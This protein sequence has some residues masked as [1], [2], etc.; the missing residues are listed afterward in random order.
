MVRLRSPAGGRRGAAEIGGRLVPLGVLAWGVGGC[1]GR[2][3]PG[4]RGGFGSIGPGVG[5]RGEGCEPLGGGRCVCEERQACKGVR[6]VLGGMFRLI[7]PAVREE[8]RPVRYRCVCELQTHRGTKCVWRWLRAHH[9]FRCAR[10]PFGAHHEVA[11]GLAA[12]SALW[13][14]LGKGGLHPEGRAVGLKDCTARGGNSLGGEAALAVA[15][16][17]GLGREQSRETG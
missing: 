16:K 17:P 13:Q 3:P 14:S 11:L 5:V 10:G 15:E 6:A 2:E 4:V 7:G 9:R 12:A 1:E 8:R